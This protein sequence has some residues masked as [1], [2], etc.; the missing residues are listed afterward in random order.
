M[1]LTDLVMYKM[2]QYQPNITIKV[3]SSGGFISLRHDAVN[4]LKL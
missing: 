3:P 1:N 4:S 2:I